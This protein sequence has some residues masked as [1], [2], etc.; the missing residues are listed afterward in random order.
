MSPAHEVSEARALALVRMQRPEH[1][2]VEV[3]RSA[4]Q[5]AE[6]VADGLRPPV[7]CVHRQDIEQRVDVDEGVIAGADQLAQ[8]L[9]VAPNVEYLRRLVA[10]LVDLRK[11]GTRGVEARQDHA[12]EAVL[13][14]HDQHARRR[15]LEAAGE[16]ASRRAGDQPRGQHALADPLGPEQEGEVAD[17]QAPGPKPVDRP[18]ARKVGPAH[19][20][21][22]TCRRRRFEAVDRLGGERPVA[23]R[24]VARSAGGG[25]VGREG[26]ALL[27]SLV[28]AQARAG[29]LRR[30]HAAAFRSA[31]SSSASSRRL[32]SQ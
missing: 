22:G 29:R 16:L 3:A 24:S 28:G 26:R 17:W 19:P 14:A 5:W 23:G 8:L 31:G 32:I 1:T 12:V 15:S 4:A 13:V 11:I 20:K 6:R 25:Q 18:D 21:S 27:R 9:G 10:E 7:I 30:D 2:H